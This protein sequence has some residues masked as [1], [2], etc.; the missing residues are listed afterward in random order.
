MINKLR[1]RK[2]IVSSKT[3]LIKRRG[4]INI[5]LLYSNLRLYNALFISLIGVN[6]L[7]AFYTISKGFYVIYDH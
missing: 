2:V 7:S 4:T 5:K 1:R 6:L 3:L